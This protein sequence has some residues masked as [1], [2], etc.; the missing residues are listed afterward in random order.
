VNLWKL[1]TPAHTHWFPRSP[2]TVR[3]PGIPSKLSDAEIGSESSLLSP[4]GLTFGT[5]VGIVKETSAVIWESVWR[6]GTASNWCEI[7]RKQI[8]EV[9]RRS[10]KLGNLGKFERVRVL[11]CHWRHE[12]HH[13][14]YVPKRVQRTSRV[15]LKMPTNVWTELEVSQDLIR[16]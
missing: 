15:L 5:A 16:C 4:V 1:R 8:A 12:H 13:L 14:P 10:R 3:I 11:T 6:F 9:M 2:A 7:K